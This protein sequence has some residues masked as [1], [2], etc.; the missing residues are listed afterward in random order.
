MDFL[1]F[2]EEKRIFLEF[3]IKRKLPPFCRPHGIPGSQLRPGLPV[4][5]CAARPANGQP[6][7]IRRQPVRRAAVWLAVWPRILS[8]GPHR[9]LGIPLRP[10]AH[11]GLTAPRGSSPALVTS[12]PPAR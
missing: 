2:L 12:G 4:A 10:R 8:G 11:V 6:Q 5:R 7:P 1:G 3:L 9:I